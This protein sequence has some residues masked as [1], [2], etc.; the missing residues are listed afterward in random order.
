MTEIKLWEA[1]L[2]LIGGLFLLGWSSERFVDESVGLARRLNA[3][4]FL[5]GMVIVGFGTSLP[6][7][8]VSAFAAL[9]AHAD[10]SL[11]NAYG[12]CSYN[13][14]VILGTLALFRPIRIRPL[15]R[16]TCLPVLL[17]ATAVSALMLAIF[18]GIPR[19]EGFILLLLFGGAVSLLVKTDSSRRSNITIPTNASHHPNLALAISL[20]LLLGSS[21]IVVWSAVLIARFLGVP[22]LVIGLT[23]VAAGTSLPELATS[24]VAIRRA[25]A[26]LVLGNILGSNLFN[27]LAVVG[28]SA[29]IRPLERI[30][31][32]VLF[33]DLPFLFILTT[34]LWT[35][36]LTRTR[37]GLLLAAFVSYTLLAWLSD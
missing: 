37:G 11:G 19:L 26:D 18:N 9:G 10:L 13:I 34:L 22:E 32:I 28:T 21:A 29:L 5:I 23:I 6:E 17:A 36:R 24:I 12:S 4:P 7:L 31:S 20:G 15:I 1:A 25:Q 16:R 27:I 2:A 8:T 3:S 35:R 30:D 14:A 33:R